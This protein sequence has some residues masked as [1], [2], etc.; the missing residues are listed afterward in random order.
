MCG[1]LFVARASRSFIARVM[2]TTRRAKHPKGGYETIQGSVLDF[3]NIVPTLSKKKSIKVALPFLDT[4]F[5]RDYGA[6]FYYY[7]LIMPQKFHEM[8]DGS[9]G[10]P[11]SGKS[12][13]K[14]R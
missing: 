1:L 9:V 5:M 13:H 14:V 10:R 11:D 2:D 12:N 7:P 6:F 3:E 4:L 8:S